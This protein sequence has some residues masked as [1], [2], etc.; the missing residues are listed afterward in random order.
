[1][2]S[3]GETVGEHTGAG[4][5]IEVISVVVPLVVAK[6]DNIVSLYDPNEFLNGVVKVKFDLDVGVDG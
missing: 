4:V 2:R 6:F 3:I 5:S 1:L